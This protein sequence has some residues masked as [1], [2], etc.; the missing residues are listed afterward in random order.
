MTFM[1]ADTDQLRDLGT[2]MRIGM[3]ALQDRQR[4]IT[5]AVMSTTW[6]DLGEDPRRLYAADPVQGLLTLRR[7]FSALITYQRMVAEQVHTIVQY[8]Y[9]GETLLEEEVTADGY[10]HF[11][12]LP[13]Q[14]AID[15]AATVIDQ[16][17]VAAEDGEPFSLRMSEIEQDERTGAVLSDTRALTVASLVNRDGEADQLTF[18]ATSQSVL[19]SRSDAD[20]VSPDPE[21]DQE[22][23]F[24]EVSPA[25]LR[26]TLSALLQAASRDA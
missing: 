9:P 25:T 21:A 24:A 13:R 17:E 3:M 18:Y 5:Q 19:V 4:E 26:E 16:D 7:T 22:L 20:L 15:H 12:V 8:L 14:S 6:E 11:S 2:R 10:H 1:G 23:E